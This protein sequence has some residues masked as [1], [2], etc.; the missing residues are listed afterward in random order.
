MYMISVQE[1]G[2]TVSVVKYCIGHQGGVWE[3]DSPLSVIHS[4][5]IENKIWNICEFFR[6]R[7]FFQKGLK[8]KIKN[9]K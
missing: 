2:E 8:C 7:F 4:V 5:G 9:K 1:V 3:G 6:K